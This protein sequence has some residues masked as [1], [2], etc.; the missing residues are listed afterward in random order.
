MPI[1]IDCFV[2][3]FSLCSCCNESKKLSSGSAKL[4]ALFFRLLASNNRKD[5]SAVLNA[6]FSR[7]AKGHYIKYTAH[8]NK[9]WRSPPRSFYVVPGYAR[10]PLKKASSASIGTVCLTFS[11]SKPIPFFIYNERITAWITKKWVRSCW[12]FWRSF[13]RVI[14]N[15]CVC[16][17]L[18]SV[19]RLQK[20]GKSK[21]R[22]SAHNR[23]ALS[24]SYH[25]L[26]HCVV[27]SRTAPT[28]P[29]GKIV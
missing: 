29:T 18:C 10:W 25:M 9:A 14:V 21:H 2:G 7:M 22:L 27:K 1:D 19:N 13:I 4:F 3:V 5:I 23:S 28:S 6:P 26:A 24:S 20:W 15:M 16:V 17:C 11:H 12:Y 8:M